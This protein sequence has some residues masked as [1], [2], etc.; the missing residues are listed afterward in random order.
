M[1]YP[2]DGSGRDSY[3]ISNSGGNEYTIGFVDYPKEWLREEKKYPIVTPVM[4]KRFQSPSMVTYN[5]WPSRQA[6]K[7]NAK[8]F[9]T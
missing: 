8:T 2:P 5:N 6:A 7:N 4:N 9:G 3:V 1:Y